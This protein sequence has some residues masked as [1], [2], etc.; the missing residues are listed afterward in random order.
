MNYEKFSDNQIKV[1]KT[2]VMEEVKSFESILSDKANIEK[3]I[4]RL[5]HQNDEQIANLQK[6][7]EAVNG[8]LSECE[9]MEIRAKPIEIVKEEIKPEDDENIPIVEEEKPIEEIKPE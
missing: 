7:L 2:V 6:E 4:D 5:T 8:L 3:E 9:K 1:L